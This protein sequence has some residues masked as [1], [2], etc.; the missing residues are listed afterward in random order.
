MHESMKA[1]LR[2]GEMRWLD[3]LPGIVGRC[4]KWGGWEHGKRT[5]MSTDGQLSSNRRVEARSMLGKYHSQKG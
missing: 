4:P 5:A 1:G 2:L 3:E